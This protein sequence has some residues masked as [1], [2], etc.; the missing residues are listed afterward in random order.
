MSGREQDTAPRGGWAIIGKPRPD[1]G[2]A[3]HND[4]SAT[5][6][7]HRPQNAAEWAEWHARRDAARR[8]TGRAAVDADDRADLLEALGLDA[9][10]EARLI[11]QLERWSR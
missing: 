8:V 2:P 10:N 11:H 6:S 3:H 1:E 9:A 7:I 4:R 5:L